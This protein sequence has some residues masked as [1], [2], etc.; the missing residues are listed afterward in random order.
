MFILTNDF[1]KSD[2]E[3]FEPIPFKSKEQLEDRKYSLYL[4]AEIASDNNLHLKFGEAKDQSIYDRYKKVTGSAHYNRM[5]YIWESEKG[6][7][8]IHDK[9]KKHAENKRTYKWDG[10]KKDND[11]TNTSES[12]LI[13]DIEAFNDF[14]EDLNMEI[15]KKPIE[16]THKE[17]W[18]DILDLVD[19]I[20]SKIA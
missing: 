2:D 9:L 7:K 13:P 3:T 19:E 8:E 15:G 12:Y 14:I 5:I 17:T 6:D 18:T 16:R 10:E 1:L 20:Y 4:Y 11:T